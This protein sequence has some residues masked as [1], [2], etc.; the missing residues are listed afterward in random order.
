MI[1]PLS[2]MSRSFVLQPLQPEGLHSDGV[3]D[4]GLDR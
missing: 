3:C 4:R 2:D 1:S